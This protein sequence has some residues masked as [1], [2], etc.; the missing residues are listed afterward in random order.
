MRT[1]ACLVLLA[2]G[3][4][5]AGPVGAADGDLLRSAPPVVV[6]TEPQAGRTDVAAGPTEIRVTFSKPM[7]DGSWSWVKGSDETFPRMTGQP[8]FDADGRTCVLPVSLEP[9]KTYALWLNHAPWQ[10]FKDRDGHPALDYLLVFS[11]RP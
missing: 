11:T 6:G 7:Q 9:G 8:H 1:V 5:P 2:L 3:L 10:Q 4:V